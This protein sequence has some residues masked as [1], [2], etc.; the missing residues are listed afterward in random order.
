MWF[1]ALVDTGAMKSTLQASD[2]M[3]QMSA[4]LN[5]NLVEANKE[6]LLTI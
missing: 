1:A 6:D 2:A 5:D 3:Q 4:I